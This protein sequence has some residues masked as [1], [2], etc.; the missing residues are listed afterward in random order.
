MWYFKLVPCFSLKGKHPDQHSI[1]IVY[2]RDW[3]ILATHSLDKWWSSVSLIS[4]AVNF[5]K[6]NKIYYFGGNVFHMRNTPKWETDKYRKWHVQYC[7][8]FSNLCW[9]CNPCW[10][11]F[12]FKIWYSVLCIVGS[13][14]MPVQYLSTH[15]ILP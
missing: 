10:L 14:P 12:L 13:M 15:R 11:F 4:Q 6:I 9:W 7:T 1:C 8:I 3:S 2:G 5:C